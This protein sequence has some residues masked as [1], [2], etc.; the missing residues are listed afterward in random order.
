MQA[1]DDWTACHD[2]HHAWRSQ[3][4]VVVNVCDTDSM[5]VPELLDEASAD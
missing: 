4:E 2:I 1:A 3:D 5:E